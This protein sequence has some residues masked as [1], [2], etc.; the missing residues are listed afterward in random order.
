M[1]GQREKRALA[2]RVIEMECCPVCGALDIDPPSD[3][4]YCERDGGKLEPR[5]YVAVDALLSDDAVRA[6]ADVMHVAWIKPDIVRAA[7]HAGV[8]AVTRTEKP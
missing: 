6:M 1:A 5:Q 4:D 7:I 8:T 3:C 2:H